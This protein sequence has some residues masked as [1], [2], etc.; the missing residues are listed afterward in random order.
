MCGTGTSRSLWSFFAALFIA[1]LCL[2]W[3][4]EMVQMPAYVEMSGHSWRETACRCTEASLGDVA[5]TF[6]ICGVGALAAGQSRWAMNGTWNVYAAAAL[7]GVACAVAVEWKALGL[8]RWSYADQ[9]PV[10]PGLSLGL[11]P[12]L[13]LGLLVPISLWIAVRWW[14]NRNH[15]KQ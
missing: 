9:M 14:V 3:P 7:L 12:L 8:G 1:A 13:Q 2:N 4:W 5:I 11:W 15:N 10:V 6:G